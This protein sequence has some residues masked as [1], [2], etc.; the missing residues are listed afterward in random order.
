[1]KTD[2]P[3]KVFETTE[4]WCVGVRGGYYADEKSRA[5]AIEEARELA[6]EMHIELIP[7]YNLA[8]EIVETVK[9]EGFVES[10]PENVRF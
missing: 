1:M 9:A 10:A 3:V 4:G 6:L 5:D 2:Y 7:I 8:G